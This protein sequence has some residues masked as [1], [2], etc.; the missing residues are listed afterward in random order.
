[1][2]A[3]SLAFR[4]DQSSDGLPIRPCYRHAA[5]RWVA[6]CPDCTAWHLTIQISRRDASA[7]PR[8]PHRL[9]PTSRQYDNSL[10]CV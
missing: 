2:R 7:E 8:A 6:S 1:M 4:P 5:N 3:Q 10:E 9:S